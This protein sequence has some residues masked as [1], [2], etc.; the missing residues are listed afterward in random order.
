MRRLS[1][2][3]GLLLCAATLGCGNEKP[4]QTEFK[5]N[6]AAV[7]VATP[8]KRLSALQLRAT[9]ADIVKLLDE[10][11]APSVTAEIGDA[12][13]AL[14]TDA[15]SGPEPSFGGQR[16]LDQTLYQQTTDGMYAVG[17][18]L[19]AAITQGTGAAR[20]RLTVAAGA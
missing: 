2:I 18:A 5:C 1:S 10:A 16:R 19:G 9:L 11:D 15:L 7:P 4:A 14:P 13:A 3:S 12:L 6:A 17:T 20:P 8:L